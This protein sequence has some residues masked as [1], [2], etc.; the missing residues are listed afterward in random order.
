MF[1]FVKEVCLKICVDHGW[2]FTQCQ[3]FGKLNSGG[4]FF[5][6]FLAP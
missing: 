4:H 2:D 1:D 3:I 5:A 6:L